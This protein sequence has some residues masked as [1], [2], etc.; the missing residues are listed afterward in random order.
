MNGPA[1][2][3]RLGGHALR[4]HGTAGIALVDSVQFHVSS[5]LDKAEESI[6]RAGV[7]AYSWWQVHPHEVDT[8]DLGEGDEVHDYSHRGARLKAAPTK[9]AITAYRKHVDARGGR[10]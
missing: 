4:D 2:A 10:P 3:N 8:A 6:R 1:E 5:S 7:A 9:R